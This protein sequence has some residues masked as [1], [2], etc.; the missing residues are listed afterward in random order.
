MP[1]SR[2]WTVLAAGP[3]LLA[4]GLV[5]GYREIALL[6]GAALLCLALA[7]AWVGAPPRVT[8]DRT[9]TPARARQG[10]ECRADVDVYSASGRSRGL[11]VT[12]PVRGPLGSHTV[13]TPVRVRGGIPSRVSYPLP[14]GRRGVLTVGPLRV[15]RHDPLGL[16]R[17][18][19]QVAPAIRVLVRPRWRYLRALPLGTAP[20]LDGLLDTALHGSIAFHAL[21]EYRLGDDLRRVH[22]RTSA[23]LGTLMVREHVDTALPR[24]AVLVDDR[25][26]AY[27]PDEDALEDVVE[28]AASVVAAAGRDG[29]PFAL[30]PASRTAVAT[31]V[32]AGLDLLAQVS[33][34]AGVDLTRVLP[35]LRRDRAGDTLLVL[36]GPDADLSPVLAARAG[37]AALV[38]VLLGKR[39][40]PPALPPGA[41][42]LA[43]ATA[44]EFADRWNGMVR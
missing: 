16:C 41:V 38:V 15:G 40:S 5:A 4:L 25:A 20:S 7:F 8:A 9:V 6:G 43:A 17:A 27:G 24:L 32:D 19:R 11:D 36:S 35:G 31:T 30:C 37:Y 12:E 21:R 39:A 42:A 28:A 34:A 26:E 3:I 22:W 2:G 44:A 10:E 33:P 18:Q 13:S 1:T 14:T 23:R 29:V